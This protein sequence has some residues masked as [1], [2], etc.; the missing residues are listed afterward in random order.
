MTMTEDRV[1][2]Y[3]AEVRERS[4]RPLPHVTSLPIGH[5]GVQTLM[6]SAADVPRLLAAV[7]A[8][9]A[10][11]RAGRIAI[12]G[13]LCP[14]HDAHR[15]F[16]ITHTEAADVAACP[17]C[18]A[19]VYDSCAA[20]GPQMRLDSCP[21]RTAISAALLTPPPAEPHPAPAPQ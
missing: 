19:T 11:H 6:A 5:E 17:Q 18:S 9:L 1:A 10:R 21:V 14:R 16:S 4:G 8:V 12:L 2:A 13:M 15:Y 20:C 3:L 7:E